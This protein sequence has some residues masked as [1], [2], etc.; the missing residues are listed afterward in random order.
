[1]NKEEIIKH[2]QSIKHDCHNCVHC[3]NVP[4]S[5]H[6]QC[7][8]LGNPFKVFM[9]FKLG[10]AIVEIKDGD[11]SFEYPVITLNPVGV[12]GGWANW[13][14]DFDPTWVDNCIMYKEI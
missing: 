13:P 8:A 11:E 5:A 6:K 12:K 14:I 2:L 9:A 3:K 10:T 1:M 4:G 7:T